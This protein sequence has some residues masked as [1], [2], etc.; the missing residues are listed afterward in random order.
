[1]PRTLSETMKHRLLD[2]P[3]IAEMFDDNPL[4]QRGRHAPIPDAV[5]VDDD[6]RTA[7]A[8]SEAWRLA[9]LDPRGAKEETLALQ[10]RR[11]QPIQVSP[12]MVGRTEAADANQDV[13]SIGVH[14]RHR[15]LQ[16]ELPA[17]RYR[18]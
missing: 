3:P 12:A 11:Q 5:G 4:Q 13:T 18:R 9:A 6:D 8:N 14:H 15:R 16:L 1:M 10:E 17:I 7:T 2:D